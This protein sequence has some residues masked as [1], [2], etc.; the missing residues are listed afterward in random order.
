MIDKVEVV[1]LLLCAVD[2][3]IIQTSSSGAKPETHAAH[4][5][6]DGRAILQRDAIKATFKPDMFMLLEP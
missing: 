2:L 6:S 4:D 1:G 3:R 5:D